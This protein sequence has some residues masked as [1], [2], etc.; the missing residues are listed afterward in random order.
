MSIQRK[1][2]LFLLLTVLLGSLVGTGA[3][4]YSHTRLDSSPLQTQGSVDQL[5]QQKTMKAILPPRLM[6]S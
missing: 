5:V 1:R 6:F 4:L 2:I 3:Y